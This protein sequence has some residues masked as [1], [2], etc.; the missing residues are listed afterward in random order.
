M[1]EWTDDLRPRL[2]SLRLGHGRE[3]EILDELSQH[4]DDRYDELRAG[5]ATDADARRLALEELQEPEAL[6]RH[7]RPLRQA[8]VPAPIAPGAPAGRPVADLWQQ[9]APSRRDGRCGWSRSPRSATS[10]VWDDAVSCEF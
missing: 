6:A 8:R 1:P 9:P 10:E 2:A 3:R 4:L 5:G 7:M